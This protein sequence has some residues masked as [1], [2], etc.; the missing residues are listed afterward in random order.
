[1]HAL[2]VYVLLAL[3]SFFLNKPLSKENSES[4]GS[5]FIKFLLFRH[6]HA[7]LDKS[8]TADIAAAL[9]FSRLDCELIFH[10]S[11]SGCL[12]RLQCIQN[13]VA[14]ILLQQPSVSSRDTLQQLHWLPAKWRIQFKLAFLTYKVLHT[15]TPSCLSERLHPYVPFRTLR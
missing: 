10:G 12:T 1:M 8:I 11:P 3:I 6:I 9:V 7:V 2:W 4:T 15:G 14:N 13:S 5:I